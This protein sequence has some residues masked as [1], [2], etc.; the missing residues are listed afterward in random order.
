MPIQRP[1]PAQQS[2]MA[3]FSSL[4]QIKKKKKKCL[5][6]VWVTSQMKTVLKNSSIKSVLILY[7][8]FIFIKSQRE[9]WQTLAVDKLVALCCMLIPRVKI[10]QWNTLIIM[11]CQQRQWKKQY[12]YS[13]RS[14]KKWTKTNN[15]CKHWCTWMDFLELTFPFLCQSCYF[16]ETN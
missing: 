7:A 5:W 15:K 14:R 8:V 10:K 13:W 9:S 2:K 4:V 16:A 1:C 12:L 3:T 11:L 6:S